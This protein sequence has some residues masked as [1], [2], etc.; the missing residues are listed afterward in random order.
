MSDFTENAVAEILK[1]Y[2]SFK[3]KEAV[4]EML[5][6]ALK[7]SDYKDAYRVGK[8]LTE[9]ISREVVSIL[10]SL[11]GELFEGT[12]IDI[13]KPCLEELHVDLAKT[14]TAIQTNKNL[15]D[16]IKIRAQSVKYSGYDAIEISKELKG[17]VNADQLTGRLLEYASKSIDAVQNKNMRFLF[18]VSDMQFIVTRQYDGVGLHN[19]KTPCSYCLALEGTKTFKTYE[20][21]QA[22]DIWKRHEGCGCYID[23]ECKYTGTRNSNVQNYR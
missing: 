2:K 9:K 14:S 23:Y 17:N 6:N 16:G 8:H 22:S 15:S 19:G 13:L 3:N 5:E 20:E 11:D 21:C 4:R 10:N 18:N 12:L 7:S 1:N